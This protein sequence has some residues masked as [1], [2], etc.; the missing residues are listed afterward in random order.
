MEIQGNIKKSMIK[1]EKKYSL[2]IL[3][4]F[5]WNINSQ[6][7]PNNP[8]NEIYIDKQMIYKDSFLISHFKQDLQFYYCDTNGTVVDTFIGLY[9]IKYK[10]FIFILDNRSNQKKYCYTKLEINRIDVYKWNGPI[11]R[12]RKK[13]LIAFYSSCSNAWY[14]IIVHEGRITTFHP[15][16]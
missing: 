15:Y 10:K 14:S 2:I 9:M 3:L 12:K 16:Q 13:R 11:R 4:V 5:C 6:I 1:K 7:I 8:F